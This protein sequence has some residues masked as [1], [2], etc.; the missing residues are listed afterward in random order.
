[1]SEKGDKYMGG[2]MAVLTALF[3]YGFRLLELVA[4]ILAIFCMVKYLKK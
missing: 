1:M 3:A 4:L 2:I